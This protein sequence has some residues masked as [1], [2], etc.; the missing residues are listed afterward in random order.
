VIVLAEAVVAAP[1]A[2]DRA[3]STLTKAE[4]RT[5]PRAAHVTALE[6]EKL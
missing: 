1:K 2:E 5:E 6:A 3:V 4:G